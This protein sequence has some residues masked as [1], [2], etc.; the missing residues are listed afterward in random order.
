MKH[1]SIGVGQLL[2]KILVKKD[3]M[4]AELILNWSKIVGFKFARSSYP[5]KISKSRENGNKINILHIG[6]D[7]PCFSMEMSFQQDVMIE[8]MVV[9]FGFKPVHKFRLILT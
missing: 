8:R 4:L 3:P 1:I 5:F 9:Y 2:R 7:N 6:V